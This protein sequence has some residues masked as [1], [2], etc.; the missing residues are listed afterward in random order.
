MGGTAIEKDSRLTGCP[1]RSV[2]VDRSVQGQ[3]LAG[4]VMLATW[5]RIV[6]IVLVVLLALNLYEAIT[7][8]RRGDWITAGI[9]ALL[10]AFLLWRRRSRQES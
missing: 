10:L 9:M 6:P 3:A 7:V 2:G 1:D 8:G 4:G 5:Q